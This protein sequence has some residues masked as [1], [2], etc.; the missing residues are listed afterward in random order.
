MAEGRDIGQNGDQV[1]GFPGK[2]R[3]LPGIVQ[4]EH[5][6]DAVFG[7]KG[8]GQDGVDEELLPVFFK[9]EG[10]SGKVF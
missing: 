1:K 7:F 8:Q 2:F 4:G 5:T 10:V 3:L 6:D 9:K